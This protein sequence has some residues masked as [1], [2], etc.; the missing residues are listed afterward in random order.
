MKLR[1]LI[2]VSVALNVLLAVQ[3]YRQNVVRLPAT[4]KPVAL[5]F[6]TNRVL[7]LPPKPV[8]VPITVSVDEPF[9][10]AQIETTDYRQYIANLRA[11]G[12][13]ELTV[14]EMVVAELR[15]RYSQRITTLVNSVTGQFWELLVRPEDMEKMVRQKQ[16]ELRDLAQERD[17]LLTDLFGDSNPL[18]IVE[19][20]EWAA[21]RGDLK[22]V[23]TILFLH[24]EAAVYTNFS[25]AATPLHSAVEMGHQEIVE[26]L[27]AAGADINARETN[28]V[29]PLH[30]AIE[31]KHDNLAAFL[32]Q[33]GASE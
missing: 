23:N 15:D 22:T 6:I 16:D 5:H 14:R 9:D 7:R 19:D 25:S 18:P 30:L 20:I 3:L 12:C 10:W 27:L 24:P 11:V 26:A 1:L 28:G 33:H 2:L 32:R 4:V 29:T 13:P 21:R 31:K 8:S 17:G